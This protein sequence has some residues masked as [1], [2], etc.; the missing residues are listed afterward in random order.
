MGI[1]RIPA[2]DADY[3]TE[4]NLSLNDELTRRNS[5]KSEVFESFTLKIVTG[6][7]GPTLSELP[8][9]SKQEVIVDSNM[10]MTQKT[11]KRS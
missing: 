11:L 8:N 3:T 5:L 7:V 2:Y 10:K 4:W 1:G 6:S 9:I